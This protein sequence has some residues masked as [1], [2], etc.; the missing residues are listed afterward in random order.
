MHFGKNKFLTLNYKRNAYVMIY[1]NPPSS[2]FY[3]FP[4]TIL[5][6]FFNEDW[7]IH[8]L[9]TF[10]NIY[11]K[12]FVKL[13]KF[14][15]YTPYPCQMRNASENHLHVRLKMQNIKSSHN[16]LKL[17]LEIFLLYSNTLDQLVIHLS[18]SI[19][20]RINFM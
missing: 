6:T 14:H 8:F 13:L 11:K 7:F 9:R 18:F 12:C 10:L 20:L 2:L 5:K 16:F 15:S 3:E 4:R 1:L 17:L 19:L